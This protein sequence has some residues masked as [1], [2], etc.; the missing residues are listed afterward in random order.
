MSNNKDL[1]TQSDA[2]GKEACPDYVRSAPLG[3]HSTGLEGVLVGGDCRR[4]KSTSEISAELTMQRA[5]VA[6]REVIESLEHSAALLRNIE[7][8]L[9]WREVIESLEQSAA[10]LRNIEALLQ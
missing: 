10:L 3:E 2:S 6:L 1:E 5:A 7:A 4:E 9:K 8:L